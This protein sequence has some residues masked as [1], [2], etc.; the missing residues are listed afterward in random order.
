VTFARVLLALVVAAPQTEPRPKP[1]KDAKPEASRPAAEVVEGAAGK[2]LDEAMLEVD[3]NDG[4]FC[5][6]VLVASKGKVLLRKGY[7]V[8]DAAAK[9]AME[10]DALYDWASVSKQFTAAAMLRLVD[11]SRLDAKTLEKLGLTKLAASLEKWRKLDL[12]DPISRFFPQAP[13]DKA[14]VTLR[15]LLNH[16]SGIGS[17]FT[18]DVKFDLSSRDALVQ[19]VLSRP[20]TSKPGAK[21]EYSNSNYTFVAA[22]VETVSGLPFEEF[23]AR[24]LFEPAGMKSATMIGRPDLDLAR[25]PKVARGAGFS[26]HP[27]A[28]TYGNRLN[29]GYRGCG[30]IVASTSDLLAWD[31]ALRGDKL[32]SKAALEQLCRPGLEDYALG[33]YVKKA[34]GGVRVQHGGDVQGVHTWFVRHLDQDWVV[35]FAA[36]YDMKASREQ[37][38][39]KLG[40][41]A[42][43]AK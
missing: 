3:K 6:V 19:C 18:D 7:G 35:A 39:E 43:R 11:A 12:D 14:A 2:A 20:M 17:A 15:Q 16:T 38:A 26:D 36:S 37:L 32:L 27:A 28:Y 33:W 10:P 41:I 42:E 22:I 34:G 21:W 30:G 1:P 5:G 9:K 24:E 31:R 23:C 8:A 40:R 25:V 4:G 29:W 13:K